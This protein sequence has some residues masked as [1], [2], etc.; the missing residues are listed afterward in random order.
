MS[1]IH[2]ETEVPGPKSRAWLA[3]RNEA[4]PRGIGTTVPVFVDTASGALVT[5]IDGNRFIDL[6]G[7]I[8]SL[9][10]GHSPVEV[11]NAIKDQLERFIHPVFHVTMYDSYIALAEKLNALVPGNFAKKTAFFNSG[12]EAV[13]NAVKVARRFTGRR[14]VI[15]FERGFHGRTLL[16]MSLT[17]KVKGLK[18]GFGT[19]AAD[20][21]KLPYPYPYRSDLTTE[22]ML[23]QFDALFESQVD[24]YDVAAV[25]LEPVQGDG[26]FMVPSIDFVRGVKDICDRYQILL[27]ADEVQTGL[28]RTGR[29]FA[30]EH[31]GVEADVTV[32]AKSLGAGIPLAAVTG[33]AEVMDAPEVKEL[34]A[35]L[36]GSPLGCA[37]GLR[38]IEQIESQNLVARAAQ[39]GDR[40]RSKLN[41][42][43]HH[44][45]EVRG[46]GAMVGIEFVTDSVRKHPD[47]QFVKQVVQ[48]CYQNG[49]LILTAGAY[50]NVVR[51]LPPLVIEDAQVD[52][53]MAVFERVVTVLESR[54]GTGST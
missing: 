16:G 17:G 13:E 35:T 14:A 31:F 54:P 43:S 30:M 22:Q 24:P 47:P 12:A 50:G 11:V 33:R 36:G 28:G 21:Y 27:I 5:D 29:W 18:R 1:H 37:A 41:F 8:S 6:A 52:E 25:V 7:G 9:N 26:G 42:L 3:R 48:G 4:V 15:S 49:V 32:M 53:A 23:G 45:G 39:I 2:L 38:V 19:M 20:V 40:I 44:I 10:V 51:L 46:L 34:G